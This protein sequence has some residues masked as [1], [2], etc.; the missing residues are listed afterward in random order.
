MIEMKHCQSA[1]WLYSNRF[2]EIRIQ[3]YLLMLFVERNLF[4]AGVLNGSVE[5]NDLYINKQ[6]PTALGQFCK[7]PVWL[8]R[9]EIQLLLRLLN[10]P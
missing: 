8:I 4:V 1:L 5:G 10:Q 3:I 6:S 7:I 9:S 2:N